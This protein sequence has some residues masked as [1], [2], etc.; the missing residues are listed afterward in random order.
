LYPGHK[1]TGPKEEEEMSQPELRVIGWW[2]PLPSHAK[3]LVE[4][5]TTG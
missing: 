2:L 3:G 5:Q 1:L 4:C